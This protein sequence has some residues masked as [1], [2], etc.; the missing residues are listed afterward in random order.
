[1]AEDALRNEGLTRGVHKVAELLRGKRARESAEDEEEEERA[2]RA[3][4]RRRRAA[5]SAAARGQASIR[6]FFG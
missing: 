2:P 1:V 5:P 6:D 3:P 4:K